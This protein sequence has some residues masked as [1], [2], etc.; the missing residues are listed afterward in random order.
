M[1]DIQFGLK[2]TADGQAFIGTVR[3][4]R[5]EFEALKTSL[6]SAGPA[7]AAV[8]DAAQRTG[9][10]EALLAQRVALVNDEIQRQVERASVARQAMAQLTQQL[11][12]AGTTQP[13]LAR[14]ILGVRSTQDILAQIDLIKRALESLKQSAGVGPQEIARATQAANEK[15]A[16]LRA[17]LDGAGTAAG[18][19][20]QLFNQARAYLAGLI[21]VGTAIALA[22]QFA[23]LSD[24]ATTLT[25]RMRNATETSA[26]LAT[27]QAQL[28]N[29]AGELQLNYASLGRGFAEVGEAV[30]D[31]GGRA[32]TAAK[33][34]KILAIEAREAGQ[35]E[36]EVAEQASLFANALTL[37]VQGW[38][39]FSSLL[40]QNDNFA[41]DLAASLGVT[42]QEL[43]R[44]AQSGEL[45]ARR[46]A[47]AMIASFD[48]IEA[49]AKQVPKTIGGGFTEIGNEIQR[50]ISGGNQNAIP[51]Y[52]SRIAQG[53][54]S[55]S[56][57]W[58]EF[59]R[60][61]LASLSDI[62]THAP[63]AA[64]AVAALEQRVREAARRSASGQISGQGVA[65]DQ[66]LF[67]GKQAF[68]SAAASLYGLVDQS[69][70]VAG[71]NR[72][73]DLARQQI[74]TFWQRM[75][76]ADKDGA[77]QYSLL[78]KSLF[79]AVERD[80]ALAIQ[81]LAKKGGVP[82]TA[83]FGELDK[84]VALAQS[85]FDTVLRI[86]QDASARALDIL[87][88]QHAAQLVSERDYVAKR[89]SIQKQ[90]ANDEITALR[91]RYQALL[92]EQQKVLAAPAVA[93]D[94]PPTPRRAKL[95]E[96]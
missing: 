46:V 69:Q 25:A 57:D 58:R 10:A 17:E 13:D 55:A 60:W 51:D 61:A 64:G 38:R 54:R 72:R 76:D 2:L 92:A 27:V 84:Q 7:T 83:L 5:Q 94:A 56:Q 91:G 70:T 24:E 16:T 82:L 12:K 18:R 36:Q 81:G 9:Q 49:R 95:V 63:E 26:E 96:N 40:K 23:A 37:G 34:V 29:T 14:S 80:R 87:E 67:G 93:D 44:M 35:S 8:G 79:A 19:A 41:R 28:R 75:Q 6:A 90:A 3:V 71:V 11:T 78:V 4:S 47:E 43:K 50:A 68:D 85:A 86:E 66:A 33:L 48:R 74:Q 45:D 32:D 59:G 21:S 20:G 39:E 52:L 73:A 30:R 53:L 88:F 62:V 1:P 15:L 31:L 65:A 89:A 42:T 22:R 77:K